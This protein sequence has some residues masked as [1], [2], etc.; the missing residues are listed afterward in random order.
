MAERNPL[1]I[2]DE[3]DLA[4]D[5]PFAELTRIMGFDPRQSSKPADVSESKVS[6]SAVAAR[7][8][9]SAA[10][11]RAFSAVEAPADDFDIDLEKELLVEFAEEEEAPA[12]AA[13]P[14]PSAPST[15]RWST[16]SHCWRI[17]GS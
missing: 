16:L 13:R 5:D 3:M 6:E 10:P 2:A 9:P 17:A 14:L 7:A 12:A 4:D 11:V 15:G 8:M 1:K